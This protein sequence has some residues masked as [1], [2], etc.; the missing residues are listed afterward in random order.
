MYPYF[1]YR[2]LIPFAA[3]I[4]ARAS[5]ASAISPGATLSTTQ[6][7]PKPTCPVCS[8]VR[9]VHLGDS[10]VTV[11][12]GRSHSGRTASSCRVAGGSQSSKL[13]G[14]ISPLAILGRNRSTRA[15]LEN[16]RL[17]CCRDIL[18]LPKD[19]RSRLSRG[20]QRLC[21]ADKTGHKTPKTNLHDHVSTTWQI[22]VSRSYQPAAALSFSISTRGLRPPG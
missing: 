13:L 22:A 11:C 2:P 4:P 7:L 10:F 14:Q 9:Q 19:L 6:R 16:Y 1:L 18:F 15:A 12:S 21:E 8:S 3:A 20:K 5:I 17:P